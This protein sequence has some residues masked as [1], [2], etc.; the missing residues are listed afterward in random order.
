M[1][2]ALL[3]R[4]VT[5]RRRPARRRGPA[6]PW[7]STLRWSFVS[8]L[9]ILAGTALPA[10]L[11]AQVRLTQE[12]ALK[13]AFPEADAFQRRTAFLDEEQWAELTTLLGEAPE[14]A[15]VT[16]YVATKDGTPVGVA[17]FDA[18]RVRTLNEVLLIA[19]DT[20][21][22]IRTVEV[23]SFAEPPEYEAPG[24]WLELFR[25]LDWEADLG[26]K[27]EVPNLTGAT[28]TTRAVKEAVRRALA[29]H[30]VLA[31]LEGGGP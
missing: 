23:V 26:M 9:A 2:P 3:I 28:L 27:G 30:R 24:G 22:R 21:G 14:R 29:L 15:V 18:H 20:A 8:A 7:N 19:V 6:P 13:L 11:Q 10:T 1:P 25:G 4:D 16:H 17:Y 31:P 5:P 12:E